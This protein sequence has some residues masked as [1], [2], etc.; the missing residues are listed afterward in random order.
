M[1][2][3]PKRGGNELDLGPVHPQDCEVC[4]KEQLFHL[5]L[6]Y[7]YEHLF[8]LFGNVRSQSYVLVCDVCKTSFRIPKDVAWKLGR[9]KQ[10][11]IP[12]HKRFGCLFLLLVIIVLAVIGLILEQ[13][14][15]K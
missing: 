1:I 5:L 12:I 15:I 3:Y 14:G 6:V 7:R 8:R 13:A 11:P 4:Q 9:L 10:N 2:P